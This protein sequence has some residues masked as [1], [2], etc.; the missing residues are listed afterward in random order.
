MSNNKDVVQKL[1]AIFNRREFSE[2]RPLLDE[3]FQCIW[4]QSK[5]L[6]RGADNFIALSKWLIFVPS[7]GNTIKCT[8]SGI[9]TQAHSSK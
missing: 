6:I 2:V 3:D 8:C 1:W 7:L 9:I 5:E 4:P